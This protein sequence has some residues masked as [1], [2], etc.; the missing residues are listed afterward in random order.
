MK[1][2][3][4]TLWWNKGCFMP[5]GDEKGNRNEACMNFHTKQGSASTLGGSHTFDICVWVCFYEGGKQN[6]VIFVH[7]G[8]FVLLISHHLSLSFLLS[9]SIFL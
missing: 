9:L 7:I 8:C 3:M 1:K 6:V 5:L 2:D 4:E